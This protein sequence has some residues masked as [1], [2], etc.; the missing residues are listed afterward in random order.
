MAENKKYILTKKGLNELKEELNNLIN[1]K[2]P[3]IIKQIAEARA[4]GDLSENADYDA[5]KAQQGVIETRINEINEI[6]EH[7]EIISEDKTK[8]QTHEDHVRVG[9][10]VKVMIIETQKE[11]EYSIVGTIE[12]DP[13]NNMISNDSPIAKALNGHKVGDIVEIHGIEQPYEMKILNI[14]DR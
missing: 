5:A 11:R 10:V 1:V 6:I 2:R 3:E 14:K 8:K 12:A 4:Q 13:F 9:K 7:S